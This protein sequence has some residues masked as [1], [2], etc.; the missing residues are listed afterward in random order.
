MNRPA[1]GLAPVQT[2]ARVG[3]GH[4]PTLDDRRGWTAVAAREPFLVLVLAIDAVILVFRPWM[5]VRSDTWLALV[6]GRL[7]SDDWLPHHDTLTVWAHGKTWVDQQWLGQLFFYWLHVLGGM[8]L[9]LLV[10]VALLVAGLGLA[11]V[12][13]RRSGGSSRS[14]ALVGLLG[15]VV[16]LPNSAARTQTF[17]YLLFVGLFWLLASDGRVPSRRVLLALPLLVFWANVH[18][19]AILGVALVVL[20]AAAAVIRCGRRIDR[21]AWTSRARAGTLAVAAPLCLFVSPYGLALGSYY[22]DVL[23]SS[24]FRDLVSEWQATTFPRQAPFFVLA[25]GAFWLSARKPRALSLFEHLALLCTLLAGLDA[26][27]NIVWFALVAVMVVP[28]ALDGTWPVVEAPV[29]ERVNLVISS[30]AAAAVV[31]AFAVA[32][33]HPAASYARGY[34]DEGANAVAAYVKG[35]PE[36]RVFANEAFAD[37]LLWKVPALS[38]RIAFDARF[39]LLNSRQLHAIADFRRMESPRLDAAADYGVVVLD[40]RLEK[41]AISTL[42]AEPGVRSLY[43]DRAVAV[44]V[45]N[46]SR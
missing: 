32:A 14:V 5:R 29:R 19:S 45:R 42:A 2:S 26:I 40:S 46:D 10:H 12:Y 4:A 8:R 24:A 7:V 44:L 38:G 43:R 21:G 27:R 23:S 11:L 31:I 20:W 16:A 39:E 17:A 41:R 34:P 30:V 25:L 9:L 3:A 22:S 13:A 36:A 1:D 15:L 37:W 33:S 35:H 18:G 6:A 28:R